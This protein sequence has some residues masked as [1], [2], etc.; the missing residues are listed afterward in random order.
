MAEFIGFMVTYFPWL[1]ATWLL[2][3]SIG[4]ACGISLVRRQR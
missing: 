3:L 1:S 2:L 4:I